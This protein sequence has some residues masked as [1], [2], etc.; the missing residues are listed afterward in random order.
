MLRMNW[1]IYELQGETIMVMKYK[2]SY[3]A[4]KHKHGEIIKGIV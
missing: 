4:P 1:M 3:P 2:G